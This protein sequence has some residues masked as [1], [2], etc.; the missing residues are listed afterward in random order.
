MEEKCKV[1]ILIF[2]DDQIGLLKLA[3][4]VSPLLIAARP[5]NFDMTLIKYFA[6]V[7]RFSSEAVASEA[8][9]RAIFASGVGEKYQR[10]RC[11]IQA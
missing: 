4:H 11:K 6:S 8:V 7:S 1:H 3:S 5:W 9:P 10:F 2:I